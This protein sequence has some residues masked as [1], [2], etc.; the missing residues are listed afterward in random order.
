MDQVAIFS[1]DENQVLMARFRKPAFSEVISSS[2]P[3]DRAP[4]LTS[5]SLYF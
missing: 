5:E 2:G 4:L 1:R 3:H